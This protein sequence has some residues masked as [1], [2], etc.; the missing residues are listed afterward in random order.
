MARTATTARSG[1]AMATTLSHL[2]EQRKDTAAHERKQA[3]EQ[4]AE[5]VPQRRKQT[6]R[7]VSGIGAAVGP[8][9]MRAMQHLEIAKAGD[10]A[11]VPAMRQLRAHECFN[12]LNFDQH[13]HR[14][15]QHKADGPDKEVR[16]ENDW[17]EWNLDLDI[18]AELAEQEPPPEEEEDPGD[19]A[20]D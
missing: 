1:T 2:A 10:E 20:D 17:Y 12:F 15:K 11:S 4:R 8:V 18:E 13:N 14:E 3:R 5:A 16:E 6:V 7:T 9:L 19:W